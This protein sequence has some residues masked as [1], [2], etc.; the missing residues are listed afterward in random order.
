MM[1]KTTDQVLLEAIQGLRDDIARVDRDLGDER[2]SME[3]IA[4]TTA[5]NTEQVRLFG[6]R[7][8]TIETRIQD[9]MSDVI[10]PM[11]EQT[12]DL[13]DTID[14]KKTLTIRLPAKSFWSKF[15]F[16]RRR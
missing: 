4:M 9:K 12:Q 13:K 11:M 10:A 15:K 5:A 7:L 8:E 1:E 3:K 6:K 14:K 16:W 2:N